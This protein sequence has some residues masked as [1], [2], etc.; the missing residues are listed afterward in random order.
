MTARAGRQSKSHSI[1]E[2][3]VKAKFNFA[4]YTFHA[5]G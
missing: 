2:N 4:E 3:S 5:L 1:S